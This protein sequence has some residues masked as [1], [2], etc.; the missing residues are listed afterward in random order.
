MGGDLMA[1]SGGVGYNPR[2]SKRGKAGL[3]G[4]APAGAQGQ[5]T[6]PTAPPSIE[7]PLFTF[8]PALS[9]QRRGAQRGLE[10]TL[11][12]IKTE[13][14]FGK[15]DLLRGL[16]R[17][18]T[19]AARSRQQLG[20]DYGRSRERLS[21]ERSDTEQKADRQ[22]Q[23]FSTRLAD[24]AGQFSDL[25]QRQGEAQNAAGVIEGGTSQAAAAARARNQAEAEAPIRVAEQR[26]EED[27]ATAL[28]RLDIAGGDLAQDR[29]IALSQLH[30]DRDFN[31]R[32]ARTEFGR[33]RFLLGRKEQRAVREGA[34]TDADLLTQ[35]V[36]QAR[37]NRPGAFKQWAQEN[38]ALM[39]AIRGTPQPGP[40]GPAVGKAGPARKRRRR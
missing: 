32:S 17:I 6:P 1:V 30:Q 3:G 21:N 29:D 15:T 13:L 5:G 26:L 19:D 33:N 37:E 8:D 28:S 11:A 10:D 2:K 27:L 34:I 18:R 20:I 4:A 25:G 16:G 22:R 9:A 36:W 40:A 39:A 12:D 38:P 23:D 24:I 35:M 7:P 31:R 14:R